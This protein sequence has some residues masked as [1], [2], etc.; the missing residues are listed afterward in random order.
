MLPLVTNCYKIVLKCYPVNLASFDSL[1]DGF[2]RHQLLF[3][4]MIGSP[5]SC[6]SCRTCRVFVKVHD[7]VDCL[8]DWI[9]GN[10]VDALI[11]NLKKREKVVIKTIICLKYRNIV[12]LKN[13]FK[14]SLINDPKLIQQKYVAHLV[15]AMCM[16]CC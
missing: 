10:L 14:K 6:H 2:C 12:S 5:D 3:V 7:E 16:L 11:T 8:S 15:W 4:M 1:S 13:F 9:I